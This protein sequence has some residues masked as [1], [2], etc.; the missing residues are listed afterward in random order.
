MKCFLGSINCLCDLKRHGGETAG[1]GP[2]KG[3]KYNFTKQA[4][5]VALIKSEPSLGSLGFKSGYR[6]TGAQQEW[7]SVR[8]ECL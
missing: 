5:N 2:R 1:S 4:L 8:T 7:D 3:A 6:V